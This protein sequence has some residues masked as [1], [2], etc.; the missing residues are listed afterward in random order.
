MWYGLVR[1][2]DGILNNTEVR[3]ATK[4]QIKKHLL[5]SVYKSLDIGRLLCS[6]LDFFMCYSPIFMTLTEN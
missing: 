1:L 5:P 6:K 3:C 2:W 4:E